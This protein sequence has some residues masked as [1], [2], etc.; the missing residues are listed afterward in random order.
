MVGN[1]V[2]LYIGFD[3]VGIEIIGVNLI[4]VFF[5]MYFYIDIWMLNMIIFWIKLV[6]FGVDGGF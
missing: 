4:D 6:D 2:K 3:F 5:M 1:D